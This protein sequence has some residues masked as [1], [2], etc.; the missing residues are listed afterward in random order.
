MQARI[1][2]DCPAPRLPLGSQA[3]R[4][5]KMSSGDLRF[6][7]NISMLF[8]E[9][10]FLDR[11]E[12]AARA[13]FDAVECHFPF[14]FDPADVRSRLRDCGLS[15]NGINTPP[16]EAGDFGLAA[17]AG[18]E[19]DFARGFDQALDWGQKV[20]VSTIHCMAGC[21]DAQ[22]PSDATRATDVFLRNMERASIH[23][24][25]CGSKL[26]IEPINHVD[27]P[28]YFLNTT[29]QA[30]SL[31]AALDCSNVLMLFDFYHVQITQGDVLPRMEK[32]WPIIGHFQFASIPHRHEPDEGEIAYG[33]IFTAI[34]QR[35]WPGLVA[36]EYNPRG[37]T[38]EGLG[39]LAAAR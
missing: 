21:I 18:R 23:A 11:I 3:V 19:D 5:G 25:D 4:T 36:A 28:G 13:G 27:R 22:E 33:E 39:W 14:A 15:M 9:L 30:A 2:S 20:G 24:R 38:L 7:A 26:L 37:P 6:S 8:S 10:A 35:N 31:I 32:H 34:A 12:A 29:E 17:L 16:G 1:D